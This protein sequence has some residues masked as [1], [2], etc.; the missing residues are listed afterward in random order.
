MLQLERHQAEWM[1]EID[2]QNLPEQQRHLAE[3]MLEIDD[4]NLQHHKASA[5]STVL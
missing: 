2:H 4:K 3:W 1:L 5:S